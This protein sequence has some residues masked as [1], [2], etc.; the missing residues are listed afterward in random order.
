[1]SKVLDMAKRLEEAEKIIA[2]LQSRSG[3]SVDSLPKGWSPL[4]ADSQ[5]RGLNSVPAVTATMPPAMDQE[6]GRSPAETVT[7][8]SQRFSAQND[9][10]TPRPPAQTLSDTTTPQE[11]SADVSIDERG[12]L[13]YYGPTS[14][15]HDPLATGAPSP[16]V[17]TTSSE[18]FLS[19]ARSVL[20]AKAK[21][22]RM[23]EGFAISNA[24]VQSEIPRQ[25][26]SKLLQLN[27]TWTSPM[28]MWVYR[29]AFMGKRCRVSQPVL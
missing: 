24:T 12:A 23:W 4:T 25:V 21:E 15:V 10:A 2:E 16:Q 5:N 8:R 17:A 13:C 6:N 14:A 20:V 27:W 22:S 18:D 28:F 9:F 7:T 19:K 11:I 26:V 3:Q 29:P 1:M